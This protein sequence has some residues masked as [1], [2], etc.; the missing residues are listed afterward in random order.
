[1]SNQVENI[2]S[3]SKTLT[4]Y[5]QDA[6]AYQKGRLG[7]VDGP[8]CIHTVRGY[9]ETNGRIDYDDG[10]CYMK[11][12]PAIEMFVKQMNIKYIESQYEMKFTKSNAY[13]FL[14]RIYQNSQDLISRDMYAFYIM[15]V[16]RNDVKVPV[17]VFEKASPDA[18]A[19]FKLR[20]SD[21]GY[22]LTLIKQVKK[23]GSI[24]MYDTGIK[25]SPPVGYYT[26]IVPRSSLY[27]EGYMLA[28][29]VGVIDSSYTGNVMAVLFK[30]DDTKPDLQVPFRG[31][32]LIMRPLFHYDC[33]E[34]KVDETER[35]EKG[36]G[37]S[38]KQ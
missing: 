26:E 10:S 28:N 23:S 16:Y 13:D 30:F 20:P 2:D 4:Q 33:E 15:R 9:F 36:F 18:V 29:S 37:S 32:Q 12:S 25:V 35:S 34:G 6:L 3:D 21:A 1:M 24:Q 7:Q 8:I 14:T 5:D 27:K 17:L 22:D 11:K 38:G 19:P 31:V